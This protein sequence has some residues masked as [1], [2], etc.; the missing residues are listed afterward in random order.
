VRAQQVEPTSSDKTSPDLRVKAAYQP[1]QQD[2]ARNLEH[3]HGFCAASRSRQAEACLR[4]DVLRASKYPQT[5][6]G[7]LEV[8]HA[9]ADRHD[10]LR[11]LWETE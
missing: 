8:L 3:D 4:R 11:E 10:D 1:G 6:R 2:A 7:K 9:A 5:A